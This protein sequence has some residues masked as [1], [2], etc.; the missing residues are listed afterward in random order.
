MGVYNL[1]SSDGK[2]VCDF[3]LVS[4][5]QKRTVDKTSLG[6]GWCAAAVGLSVFLPVIGPII[7][8]GILAT[9]AAAVRGR[10]RDMTNDE[11]A[12]VVMLKTLEHYG[13]IRLVGNDQIQLIND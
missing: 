2:P 13:L 11:Q 4:I 7:A 5:T 1:Y 3:V 6:W 10:I 9:T 8:S 12:D